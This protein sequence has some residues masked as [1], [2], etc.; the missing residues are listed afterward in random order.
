MTIFFDCFEWS[1]V[2]V[3][4]IC[5]EQEL[6]STT[7]SANSKLRSVGIRNGSKLL[8]VGS[9]FQ[10]NRV[11]LARRQRVLGL[12]EVD[13]FLHFQNGETLFEM[14]DRRDRNCCM[15]FD[16]VCRQNQVFIL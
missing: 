2:W 4:R 16:Q 13:A 12:F 10:L 14:N 15:A 1:F 9:Q 3:S 11:E 6:M 8:N 7:E 5:D